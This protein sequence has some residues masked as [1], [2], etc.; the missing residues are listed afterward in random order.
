ML[1]SYCGD[2]QSLAGTTCIPKIPKINIDTAESEPRKGTKAPK[3]IPM[4][5]LAADAHLATAQDVLQAH[6]ARLDLRDLR[7]HQREKRSSP[8]LKRFLNG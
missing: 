1:G 8:F 7:A 5:N 2:W 4:G 3:K 6:R